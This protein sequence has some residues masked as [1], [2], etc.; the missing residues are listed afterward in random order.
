MKNIVT[1]AVFAALLAVGSHAVGD[2]MKNKSPQEKERL[3][4][5]KLSRMDERLSLTTEQETQIRG[6]LQRKTDGSLDK[7]KAHQEIRNVLTEDQR[8]QYDQLKQ[9]MKRD[10]KK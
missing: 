9:E 1:G 4:A 8:P 2:D 5:D 7:D 10:K 6:I 3:I